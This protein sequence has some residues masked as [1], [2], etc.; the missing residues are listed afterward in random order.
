MSY[1]NNNYYKKGTWNA[2]CDVC[3]FKYK[4]DQMKKRWDG[5]FVC[6]YDW[7]MDHPQKYLKVREDSQDVPW[8]RTTDGSGS[9]DS[10][11]GDGTPPS[12][13]DLFL[14]TISS[15]SANAGDPI[16]HTFTFNQ[17]LPITVVAFFEID[18]AVAGVDYTALVNNDLSN[19]VTLAYEGL[20]LNMPMGISSFTLTVNTLDTIE[21]DVVYTLSMGSVDASGDITAANPGGP[22]DGDPALDMPA[23]DPEQPFVM[24]LVDYF[25]QDATSDVASVQPNVFHQGED[26]NFEYTTVLAPDGTASIDGA[27][28]LILTSDNGNSTVVQPTFDVGTLVE[29]NDASMWFRFTDGGGVNLSIT[30]GF[31][32]KDNN[33]G[34]GTYTWRLLITSATTFLS[35]ITDSGSASDSV[36]IP[37]GSLINE[38]LKLVLNT[39]NTQDLFVGG[40]LTET[41]NVTPL[42]GAPAGQDTTFAPSAIIAFTSDNN[43]NV[44][45]DHWGVYGTPPA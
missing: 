42:G 6:E 2:Y 9:S 4:A 23:S 11:Q 24:Y 19:G 35:C 34:I 37:I 25:D 7:E 20:A 26:D 33:A 21:D 36:A 32:A 18:G 1:A 44:D 16:V 30:I 45:I 5:L 12:G 17:P 3:G 27:G 10:G 8:V 22:F 39:D 40:V 41:F 15:G 43:G 31:D 38:N 28:Q 14:T 13:S 29:I